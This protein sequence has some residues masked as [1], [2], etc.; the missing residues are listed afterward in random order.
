MEG[1][2]HYFEGISSFHRSLILVGGIAFFW[3]WESANPLFKFKYPKWQHAGVN[4]F[5]TITTILV[6]FS[7]A[8]FLLL[9]SDWVVDNKF[10]V[11]QWLPFL[12][13][14]VQIL[15]GL[16]LLDFIGAWLIHWLE[17]KIKWLW[18]FHL[19]HHTDTFVDTTTANRHH[20]GESV[21]RFLFTVIAVIVS[22]SPLWLVFLYQ[23][24]SV[25]MAQF[26]H[27]NIR[28]PAWIETIL[29]RIIVTPGMHHVHHH[30]QQPLTDMN[31]GNIFS[32]WDRIFGTYVAVKQ[33]EL[34]YGVDT[35]IYPEEHSKVKNLLQIPFQK[36]RKP[37]TQPKKELNT[38]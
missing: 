16:L 13:L 22:G 29:N 37:A 14:A 7:L 35:H 3:I 11:I 12:P 23:S 10:G 2:V 21:F 24:I 1:I 28:L 38:R 8:F 6:N 15:I 17:H 19:I 20:P 9:T 4:V 5:F 18:K 27:A 36:Y 26:N 25:V 31:Y 33:E 30:Y 32:L 34:C